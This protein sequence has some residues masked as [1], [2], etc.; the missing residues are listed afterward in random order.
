VVYL[1]HGIF[2][3]ETDF[4]VPGNVPN[5]LDNMI[6]KGEIE[7]TVVVTMGNHFTG[8]DLG[9]GSYNQA[10]AASNLVQNILPFVERLYNVSREKEGRAYGG[11]S[12]GGMTGGVVIKNYPTVFGYYGHF[13]GN[14][15]LTP[16]DYDY[17]AS[18]NDAEDLSVFLGNGVFEGSLAAQNAI[19]A[20]F[21]SRGIPATTAQVRG[22]HDMMTG[23]QLFTIFARDHLWTRGDA[24]PDDDGITSAHQLRRLVKTE[25]LPGKARLIGN[26]LHVKVTCPA[27][28]AP[29][30]CKT[31]LQGLVQGR[32]SKPATAGKVVFVQPGEVGKLRVRV[33]PRYLARYE[34]ARKVFVKATVRVGELKVTV[35]QWVKL[36]H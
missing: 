15:S 10:N 8:T 5:I 28:A 19:A 20:S 16:A 33:E 23:G 7:P 31:T 1:A 21:Q 27:I 11:F 22:A 35:R 9:F 34:A 2:G 30:A 12:Y 32:F 17:I 18:L 24:A 29:R 4:L 3:D 14:P 25:M 26:K 13:S 6:A 36:A